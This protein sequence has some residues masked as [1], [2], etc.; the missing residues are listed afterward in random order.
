MARRISENLGISQSITKTRVAVYARFSCDKQRDESIEDQVNEAQR[1]CIEHDYIIVNVYPDYAISGR[2]DDRP[3]FLQMIED[4]KQGKFD[5]VLVWKMDRFARNMQDQYY[6]EKLIN[7]AGVRL[8][9]VKER[10]AG[11][12]IEASMSKGMLAI[13]AQIRSQQS[14]E[15]TMR[16]MLGKA[17]KCQYLGVH[18]FGYSHDGDTITLDPVEAP[19]AQEIHSRYLKGQS[20]KEIVQWLNDAGVKGAGGKPVGDTFV[21]GILKNMVY[22][23][24]Y[25]W[26]KVK[27]DRGNVVKGPDGKPIPLVRV[28]DGVPAIVTMEEKERC[29]WRLQYRKHANAK[30]DYLLSGKL[31]CSDCELPMHGETCKNHDGIPF[32]RYCCQGQRKACNGV[33]WKDRT[34][35]I[36]AKTIRETL[37]KKDVRELIADGYMLFKNN[38]RPEA[39]IEAVKADLKNIDKQRQN[40]VK[41]VED[42]M[43]Y[44]HVQDKM[45]KLDAQELDATRKLERFERSICEITK[46]DALQ[47]LELLADGM[48]SDEELLKGFVSSVWAKGNSLIAV[49]NFPGKDSTPYEI[50]CIL[51][52]L[53]EIAGQ[54]QVRFIPSLGYDYPKKELEPAGQMLVREFNSWLPQDEDNTNLKRPTILDAHGVP[55]VILESGFGV[56]I[57]LKAA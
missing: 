52:E 38:Q 47:F 53:E 13:F 5:T 2:S 32:F 50:E 35:S 10:I 7:D 55:V 12:S 48:L 31:F 25:T 14:A 24:V 51:N 3:Q 15:D 6:Y 40:L 11:N 45:A 42:G 26:G 44:K 1:Y 29:L 22:A 20:Q 16:G 56:F 43:P 30:A 37:A 49:M 9:S 28:E 21:T 27:D 39:S 18:W 54:A 57:S 8:E 36:V 33:F 4:A 41:A 19:I 23:G 34:E 46:A 17:R